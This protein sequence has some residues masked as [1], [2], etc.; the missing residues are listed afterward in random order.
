MIS[1]CQGEDFREDLESK[2]I[3][4]QGDTRHKKELFYDYVCGGGY[5]PVYI[6]MLQNLSYCTFKVDKHIHTH[7]HAH[8]H[9]VSL[10]IKSL[11]YSSLYKQQ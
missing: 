11:T 9:T 10:K 5:L 3:N 1:A 6:Y 7:T 2:I 8:T 4:I